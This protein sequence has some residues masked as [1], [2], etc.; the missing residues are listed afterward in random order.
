MVLGLARVAPAQTDVTKTRVAGN[1]RDVD[2]GVLPGATVVV[3][4]L[5]KP[6]GGT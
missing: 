6:L 4:T 2:G 5:Q 1:I 3:K